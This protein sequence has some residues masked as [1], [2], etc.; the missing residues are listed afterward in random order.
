M[1][2]GAL[3]V[4]EGLTVSRSL[5]KKTQYMSSME[6]IA[7]A[8]PR[9][10]VESLVA[11]LSD[12][13]RKQLSSLNTAMEQKILEK[14]GNCLKEHYFCRPIGTKFVLGGGSNEVQVK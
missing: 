11:H 5:F 6:S 12:L 3:F 7:D 13:Q 8:H 4:Y 10:L 1:H 2:A 9:F 14:F